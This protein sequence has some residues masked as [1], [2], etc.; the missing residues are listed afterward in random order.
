MLFFH[1]PTAL[2]GV[3]G[4]QQEP[5]DI[6]WQTFQ[7]TGT[8]YN[9]IEDIPVLDTQEAVQLYLLFILFISACI[10]PM[11]GEYTECSVTQ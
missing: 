8:M 7:E 10:L 6:T 11:V 2:N 1:I 4:L 3:L 9:T 5:T